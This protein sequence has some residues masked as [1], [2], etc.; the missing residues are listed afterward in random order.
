M[1]FNIRNFIMKTI[2]GMKGAYPDFQMR[3]YALNWYEKGK[4]TE[5]DLAEIEDFI[6]V[7]DNTDSVIIE[8]V[9][10]ENE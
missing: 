9:P 2:K 1:T 10:T 8:D 3:E 6:A 5:D 7:V 4:L